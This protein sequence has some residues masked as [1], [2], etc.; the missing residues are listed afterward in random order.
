MLAT[1]NHKSHKGKNRSESGTTL[2]LFDFIPFFML[3]A[4]GRVRATGLSIEQEANRLGFRQ[5]I[6]TPDSPPRRNSAVRHGAFRLFQGQIGWPRV[7]VPG[8]LSDQQLKELRPQFTV[9]KEN[10]TLSVRSLA[11]GLRCEGEIRHPAATTP[12][13]FQMLRQHVQA[14]EWSGW[15][16]R[17]IHRTTD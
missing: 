14:S 1:E 8:V 2:F 7:Q 11:T 3:R 12:R 5:S 17:R 16:C 10:L 9:G 4:R 15:P 6:G 13:V